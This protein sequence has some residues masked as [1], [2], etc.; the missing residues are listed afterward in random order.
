MDKD[1]KRNGFAQLLAGFIIVE[2]VKAFVNAAESGTKRDYTPATPKTSDGAYGKAIQGISDS[3][4]ASYDK[5]YAIGDVP[6][7]V[8]MDQAEGICAIANSDMASYDKRFAI[9]NMFK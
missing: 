7:D 5:N 2:L 8:T 6:L 1:K 9:G 3:T 4:M